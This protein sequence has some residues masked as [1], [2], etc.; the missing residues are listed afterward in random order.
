MYTYFPSLDHLGEF[1]QS[2]YD[3]RLYIPQV[4]V[5]YLVRYIRKTRRDILTSWIPD[6]IFSPSWISDYNIRNSRN[7]DFNF[8]NSFNFTISRF[9]FQEFTISTTW[10]WNRKVQNMNSWS[11]IRKFV[12]LISSI[13]EVEISLSWSWIREFSMLKTR[14]DVV[15]ILIS[16]R[17]NQEFMKL[18]CPHWSFVDIY[19][20]VDN[21]TLYV[22]L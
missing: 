20:N 7:H 3:I 5:K 1:Y 11:W 12:N 18:K 22:I 4:A 2:S 21:V 17:W 16:W 6:F 8:M 14:I 19:D 9:Q 15:K 13:S 10:S